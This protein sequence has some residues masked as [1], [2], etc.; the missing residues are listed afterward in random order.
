MGVIE[1]LNEWIIFRSGCVR[2]ELT[3][4]LDRKKEKLHLLLG[5]GKILLDIDRQSA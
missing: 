4:D 2:R 3:F 1:I 5:L